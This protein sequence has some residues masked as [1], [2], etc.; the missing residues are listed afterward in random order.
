MKKL[1]I[2]KSLLTIAM[3]LA[4]SNTAY[5]ETY[6]GGSFGQSSLDYPGYDDSSSFKVFGGMRNDK[7]GFEAS[8]IDL[9]KF[10]ISGSGG[11]GHIDVT[12]IEISAVGYLPISNNIDLM[13]KAGLF[14]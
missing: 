8:Y 12:S 3:A 6:V 4:I 14:I 9:G 5:S 11:S 1:S 10:D 2:G 7:P 13:A